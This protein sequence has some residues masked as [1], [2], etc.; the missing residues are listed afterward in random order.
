M[1]V[2]LSLSDLNMILE[3][4]AETKRKFESYQGYP[5]HEFKIERIKSVESTIAKVRN[6]RDTLNKV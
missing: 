3:S 1:K 6:I 4:L 5:S 2:E